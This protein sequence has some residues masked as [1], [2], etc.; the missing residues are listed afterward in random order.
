MSSVCGLLWRGVEC[1]NERVGFVFERDEDND[2][3]FSWNGVVEG[4]KS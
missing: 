3:S 1:D 2:P 4:E